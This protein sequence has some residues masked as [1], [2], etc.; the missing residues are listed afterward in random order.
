MQVC[1]IPIVHVV[2]KTLTKIFEMF[3]AL[4]ADDDSSVED[5]V[6]DANL[7]WFVWQVEATMDSVRL[8]RLWGGRDGG[9]GAAYTVLKICS[10]L[11][12]LPLSPFDL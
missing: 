3:R 4:G 12:G 7:S 9:D 5:D 10:P 6:W 1:E 8:W 11:P 2:T